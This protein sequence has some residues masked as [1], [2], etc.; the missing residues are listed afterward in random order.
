[1]RRNSLCGNSLQHLGAFTDLVQLQRNDLG[2]SAL[3]EGRKGKVSP[4][5]VLSTVKKWPVG[6]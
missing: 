1:M 6:T 2:M 3:Y 4:P 5:G